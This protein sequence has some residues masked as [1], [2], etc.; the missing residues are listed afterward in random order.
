MEQIKEDALPLGNSPSSP[1]YSLESKD[2]LNS[3]GANY[4]IIKHTHYT[5]ANPAT[6]P[7]PPPPKKKMEERAPAKSEEAPVETEVKPRAKVE[8]PYPVGS[9]VVAHGL[10]NKEFN[11]K[12]GKVKKYKVWS[13]VSSRR[14]RLFSQSCGNPRSCCAITNVITV[15]KHKV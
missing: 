9:L 13:S 8:Q 5:T 3:V 10:S 14:N 6:T 7:P 1:P 2:F 11:G 12:K 4:T 15:T